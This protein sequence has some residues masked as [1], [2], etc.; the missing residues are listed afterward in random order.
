M[1]DTYI[2]GD[3]GIP[4][5]ADTKQSSFLVVEDAYHIGLPQPDIDAL[6]LNPSLFATPKEPSSHARTL[7]DRAYEAGVHFDTCYIELDVRP[8]PVPT[9][10][11]MALRKLGF[12][13]DLK[14]GHIAKPTKPLKI[15]RGLMPTMLSAT[16]L[17][18][19]TDLDA[20]R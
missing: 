2:Y 4:G 13:V 8:E 12:K 19:A 17:S 9:I 18:P 20:S 11:A 3:I 14:Q 5:V 15:R 16:D 6:G 10:G 1:V 7:G